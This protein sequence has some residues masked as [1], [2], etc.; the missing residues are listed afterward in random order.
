M[1]ALRATAGVEI[2]WAIIAGFLALASA[3]L[4]LHLWDASLG[5]PIT[6]LVGDTNGVLMVVRNMQVSGWFQH[7][8]DLGFPFGQNLAA[9]PGW[10]GDTW[11]LVSLKLLSLMF[12]P[13]AAVNILY[14]LGFA[15]VAVAAYVSFR[16]VH[17]SR[18]LACALSVIYSILPYHFLRGEAH[19]FLSEYY[20]VPVG[21]AIAVRL[22]SGDLRT[23]NGR[24]ASSDGILMIFGAVLLLGGNTYYAVFSMIV[25]FAAG[26]LRALA[27]RNWRPALDAVAFCVI[28]VGGVL[29]E[30]IPNFVFRITSSTGFAV[31]GRTYSESEYYGLKLDRLLLPIPT[32]RIHLLAEL[33][34]RVSDTL[35]PGE[36]TETLGI[37][38]SMGLIAVVLICLVPGARSGSPLAIRLRSMGTLAVICILTGTVA[39]LNGIL[40][41][42]GYTT[43]HAWNRISVL[44]AFFALAGFGL[45]VDAGVVLAA[46]WPPAAKMAKS[47]VLGIA[48][49][50]LALF[51]QTSGAYVPTYQANASAWEDNAAYF[52]DLQKAL[53]A[54]SPVFQL[55]VMPFPESAP[56][57]AM[58]D[59]DHLRGY[60]HSDLKWSY[61]GVKGGAVEWQQAAMDA[62]IVDALP[63]LAAAGFEAI[64]VNRSGYSDHG[65]AVEAAIQKVTGVT[66]PVV[67][68]SGLLATYNIEPWVEK[69]RAAN[70]L[71]SPDLVLH[72]VQIT[73]GDGAYPSEIS[74]TSNWQWGTGRVIGTLTNPTDHPVDVRI[75][76][77]I[78][79]AT[80]DARTEI[81]IGGVVT[82][83]TAKAGTISV[84]VAAKLPAGA[85]DIRLTTNSAQWPAPSDPR[86]LIQQ[87]VGFHVV[88]VT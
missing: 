87:L 35:I 50:A 25:V 43:I 57:V 70:S 1:R 17:V 30:A 38:G 31:E 76:G 45:L 7:T 28:I 53:G 55:P 62:G 46:K 22:V 49:V 26:A 8:P 34:S 15:V 9:Y 19:L 11:A 81:S 86:T 42:A 14:V 72:P 75:L 67:D 52:A 40:A 69:M 44:I 77:T 60:L 61:G 54:G 33:G 13:A 18:Q 27:D 36:P 39:G 21:C 3:A 2:G 41:V 12:S 73:F 23:T 58:G 84:N 74:D 29:I 24:A 37:I 64:Y 82:S 71:P 68:A 88:R 80:P 85:T 63:M 6:P 78:H 4:T 51:D 56:I 20:A 65:A 32:H 5:V 83:L 10:V 79:M 66:T 47:S 59:Y 16:I 48:L